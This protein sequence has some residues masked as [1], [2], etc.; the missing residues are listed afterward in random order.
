MDRI[1][2]WGDAELSPSSLH[3]HPMSYFPFCLVGRDAKRAIC[4]LHAV[5][6][7]EGVP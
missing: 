4:P 5:L 3:S 2:L 6:R 7:V 1:E